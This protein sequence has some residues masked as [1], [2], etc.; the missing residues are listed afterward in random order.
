MDSIYQFHQARS[1]WRT[2][3]DSLLMSL[4]R[5]APSAPEDEPC[6][7][8]EGELCLD[9]NE[10]FPVKAQRLINGYIDY[11]DQKTSERL[12]SF[13]ND[14][15]SPVYLKRGLAP[16]IKPNERLLRLLKKPQLETKPPGLFHLPWEQA[17]VNFRKAYWDRVH[18]DNPGEKPTQTAMRMGISQT[19]Y[20]NMKRKFNGKTSK[21]AKN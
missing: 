13:C 17:K 6:L 9:L 18:S 1:L 11:L 14:P 20:H 21:A 5:K 10:E 16:G 12:E 7:D 8:I 2:E 4:R 3:G 19:T 15:T